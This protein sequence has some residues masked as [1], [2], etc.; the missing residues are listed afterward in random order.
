MSILKVS[1][2]V[3]LNWVLDSWESSGESG[4]VRIHACVTAVWS[5]GPVR[6][7]FGHCAGLGAGPVRVFWVIR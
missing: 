1:C 5:A 2:S 4:H 6:T 3:F 7:Y